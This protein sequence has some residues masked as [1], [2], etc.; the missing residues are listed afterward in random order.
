[1][2]SHASN[3]TFRAANP[4]PAKSDQLPNKRFTGKARNIFYCLH[5]NEDTDPAD[6][7]SPEGF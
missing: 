2:A 5:L 6:W 4:R 7:S 3:T 1:M